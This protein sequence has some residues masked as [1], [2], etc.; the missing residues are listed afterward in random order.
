MKV[1]IGKSE[2]TP[3]R[4]I[5]NCVDSRLGSQGNRGQGRQLHR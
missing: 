5:Q 3:Q 4:W 2:R 1:P